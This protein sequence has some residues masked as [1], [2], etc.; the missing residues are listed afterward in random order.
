MNKNISV[1][2]TSKKPKNYLSCIHTT[3]HIDGFRVSDAL[4]PDPVDVYVYWTNDSRGLQIDETLGD[5]LAAYC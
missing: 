1:F 2:Q 5:H 3:V 4:R